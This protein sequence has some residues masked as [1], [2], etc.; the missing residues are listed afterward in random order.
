MLALVLV[1]G[2][3]CGRAQDDSLA[4]P[5]NVPLPLRVGVAVLINDVG[6]INE[7][8]SYEA[9]IDLRYRWRDPS[10]AFSAKDAGGDRVE[11]SN[12]AMAEKLKKT[13][14]PRLVLANQNGDALRKEGG[15]FIYADGTVE[16]IQRLK[17][18][19]DTKYKLAAF[20][21]DTQGLMVRVLSPRYTMNQVALVQDQNDINAS[22]IKETISIAGWKPRGMEFSSTRARGWNGDSYPEFEAHILIQRL[23]L[24]HLFALMIPFVL[25]LLVP[26]MMTLY[27][28]ADI[29]ARMGLWGGSILALI[30]LN[31]TFS[32]RYPAL[33]SDSLVQ[34]IITIGFGFQLLMIA[35]TVTLLNPQLANKQVSDHVHAELLAFLRWSLPVG[36]FGLILT[37]S[38]LTAF[39]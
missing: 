11:F 4:M 22:G 36:L 23:P 21:F 5:S 8:G 30:A 24:A 31:F 35:I 3:A 15:L 7:N 6:K 29:G 27:I 16:H 32:V 25:L 18:T 37:R 39:G 13:W 10:L 38:L 19:L 20:P 33:G 34:Q 14:T 9:S 12:E 26:T 2:P 17:L 1:A 28:K